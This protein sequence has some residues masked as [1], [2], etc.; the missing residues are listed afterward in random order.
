MY[1]SYV[2]N[3]MSLLAQFSRSDLT[4][5]Q[6]L[7]AFT[8]A[9]ASYE[10]LIG[11]RPYWP[12]KDIC[13]SAAWSDDELK[14]Y[15]SQALER[16]PY[17]LLDRETAPWVYKNLVERDGY[18]TSVEFFRSGGVSKFG[19]HV[20][21]YSTPVEEESFLLSGVNGTLK[22]MSFRYA[23]L[24]LALQALTSNEP[25]AWVSA[26]EIDNSHAEVSV[27]ASLNNPY[28]TVRQIANFEKFDLASTQGNDYSLFL[29]P[30]GKKWM[31]LNQ[32]TSDSTDQF[33][34]SLHGEKSFL[35]AVCADER[36]NLIPPHP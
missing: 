11:A 22:P 33:E 15:C 3:L 12:I 32:Y 7:S 25:A 31:L 1:R 35:Q 14:R 9:V 36:I 30:E 19:S 13:D 27:F 5:E 18:Y 16:L 6:F 4:R 21:L 17:E 20:I 34:V 2:I 28:N 26:Y 8:P 24:L 29:L 10:A 23:H